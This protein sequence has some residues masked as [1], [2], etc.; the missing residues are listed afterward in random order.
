MKKIG[1]LS[2][3]I[4]L[5]CGNFL[6]AQGYKSFPLNNNK[7]NGDGT[8]YF[9]PKTELVIRFKVEKVTRTQGIYSQSAYL[10]G[11]DNS[12]LKNDV[13]YRV[14]SADICERIAP[15]EDKK[16]LINASDKFTIERTSA[17]TLKS[18]I[19]KGKNSNSIVGKDENGQNG[20]K[21][22][23][24]EKE[25]IQ[26]NVNPSLAVIPTYEQKLLQRGL[27]TKYPQMTAEKT[28]NE[29]KRLREKQIELLSGGWEGTYMNTTVDYM[30]KQLD[31]IINSY[32]S[33]FTGIEESTIEEYVFVITPEKPIILE[34][35]LIVP[36]CK[37][38]QTAGLMDLNEK[39]EG[40]KINARLHS[41]VTTEQN[42][43]T[44]TGKYVSEQT[45]KKLDKEGAGVYY[46]Q[47]QNVKVTLQGVDMQNTSKIVKLMQYGNINYTT[48]HN[49]NVL[50]DENTGEL[51]RMW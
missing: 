5:L 40:I 46:I 27:L 20:R 41:Y 10:L 22:I 21:H 28:A 13:S 30:Y 51:L 34:E 32:V 33:L 31:E 18:V 42:S 4:S 8:V 17:G 25:N 29:I 6:M 37:F 7:G 48:D 12:A 24:Y 45:K 19:A 2:L 49:S 23:K 39:G 26:N 47:P 44:A 1:L 16:Y 35:D 15:N 38:S 11:I 9:L 14:L 43:K 36:V 3:V 50:F